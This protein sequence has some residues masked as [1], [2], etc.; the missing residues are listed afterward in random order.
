MVL[1]DKYHIAR[2]L[3]KNVFNLDF[4][5]YLFIMKSCKCIIIFLYHLI[6]HFFFILFKY[7]VIFLFYSYLHGNPNIKIDLKKI[8]RWRDLYPINGMPIYQS[9]KSRR[10]RLIWLIYWD[11]LIQIFFKTLINFFCSIWIST[12]L[13]FE[14]P[15]KS[16][17]SKPGVL[18]VRPTFLLQW[19]L[20]CQS[21][22][23][24]LISIYL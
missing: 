6:Y 11:I 18:L 19:N 8:I 17:N 22:E 7:F 2:R 9:A 20:I 13:L 1:S 4:S 10:R 16:Q 23:M 3:L 21:Y 15:S 14:V 24:H 5:G 12:I